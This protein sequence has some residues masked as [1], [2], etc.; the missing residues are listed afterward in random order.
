[1]CRL[2]VGIALLMAPAL[3]S[4][5][6]LER[7]LVIRW[8]PIE[9]TAQEAFFD[10]D[11]PEAYL[12][13]QGGWGAGKTM[14]LTA[15]MLKLSAINYPLRGLWTV[16]D[17]GHIEDTVLETIKLEDKHGQRWLLEDSQFHYNASKKL[18]TWA[19]GGPIQFVTG[20]NPDSI[21]GPNVAFAG[22]DEP[23]SVP[24][25]AWK[26][27]VARVRH[28]AA[29]LR[30]KVA[31]GTSEGLNYL[32]DLFGPDR[33]EGYFKYIMRT[34]QNSELLDA[35]PKYLEQVMANATEAELASYL[36]GKTV[37]MAGG[38]AYPM[39]DAERQYRRF[40]QDHALP[41]RITF[42][43]NVDPMSAIVGQQWPGPAGT[44]YGALVALALPVSTVDQVCDE[45]I[46]RIGT[47]P[48]GVVIYGD[49]S[50]KARSQQSNRS[51]YDIIKE[52]LKV[53]GPLADKVPAANP[54]VK[55]RLNSVN[56]LC[57]DARGVRRF[58]V[59][60]DPQ[61]PRSAPT[62]DLVRSLQ[63]T[64]KKPGTEDIW[65]KNGETHTHLGDALGY[66]LDMEEP[67][68]RPT[69]GVATIKVPTARAGASSTMQQLR[70]EKSA[71][72][73]RELEKGRG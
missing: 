42:D 30:Q 15:K 50:G 49:A 46:R 57:C 29:K 70:A 7:E 5:D 23:G 2:A 35:H 69:A 16:P 25:K 20:E 47:H 6:A 38:L 63:Q 9:G 18:F 37:N 55:R 54:A 14:T 52:R 1:V 62:R 71:R 28:T 27:T 43:F 39:F 60:G 32:A 64:I 56:R 11:I 8:A 19:G 40:E 36:E 4:A 34:D 31:A 65:K 44:E 48:A 51:N 22:M 3:A 12:L 33:D 67:A 53:I 59:A 24:Q 73:R 61:S 45:L 66:W 21:A 10:N 13:F 68:E 41:L 26:N 58:F 17:Y 72:L